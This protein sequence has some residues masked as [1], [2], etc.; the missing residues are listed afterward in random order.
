MEINEVQD[1][2]TIEK[3]RRQQQKGLCNTI[4]DI[5]KM[6][7]KKLKK[8]ENRLFIILLLIITMMS[9]EAMGTQVAQIEATFEKCTIRK[10]S[11]NS[12][13]IATHDKSS[14]EVERAT[15]TMIRKKGSNN[16]R[17]KETPLQL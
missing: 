3:T 14:T 13:H 2:R 6:D 9:M 11:I 15:K 10:H 1:E 7:R 12:I 8:A 4:S 16:D 5:Y 17:T